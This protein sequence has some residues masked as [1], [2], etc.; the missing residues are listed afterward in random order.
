MALSSAVGVV[1][2]MVYVTLA[3]VHLA[4]AVSGKVG[5]SAIPTIDGRPTFTPGR[6]TTIAVAAALAAAAITVLLRV[7]LLASPVS[8]TIV[9][10]GTYI[11]G[12]VFVLR[13]IGDFRVVGFFKTVRTTRFATNDT[14]FFSPLCLGLGGAVLWLAAVPAGAPTEA[15]GAPR[16]YSVVARYPHDSAAYTQGLIHRPG[17]IL[18]ESTGLYG[19]SDL[20]RVDL[21]TGVVAQSVPLPADRFGE[22][23]ALH[24]GKLYQL[25][26]QSGVA[27]V[28]DATTLKRQDSVMYQGEG[29]GLTSDGTS[30]IMS[31]GSDT[32]RFRDPAT[33][34]VR[35][36]VAVRFATREPVTKLNEL[37]Y[38]GSEIFANV[39]Q[40]DWIL[41]IDPASGEVREILDF[42]GLLPGFGAAETSENVLNGIAFDQASGHLYITG[43]RWP[44]LVEVKLNAR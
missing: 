5:S 39:F 26:W 43:K 19:Q 17:G 42:A 4:W 38:V 36:A 16:G 30:L 28:Y 9:R 10:T 27:Y 15:T 22:G 11:L 7:G 41:R 2:A 24:G 32:L 40:S 29:W 18:L 8:S 33:F 31:D 34:K 1:V 35:R 3:A 37:E 20:R 14:R 25:T 23:L 12:A 13:A 21:K 6:L 44:K